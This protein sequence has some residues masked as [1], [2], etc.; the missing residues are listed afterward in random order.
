[1]DKSWLQIIIKKDFDEET[2]N[3]YTKRRTTYSLKKDV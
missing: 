1:M 3:V 2:L